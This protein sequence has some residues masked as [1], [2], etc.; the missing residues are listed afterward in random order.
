MVHAQAA[1]LVF[2]GDQVEPAYTTFAKWLSVEH[3]RKGAQM[4]AIAY[5]N[6]IVCFISISVATR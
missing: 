2:E 1:F 5:S 3:D 4:G 6:G